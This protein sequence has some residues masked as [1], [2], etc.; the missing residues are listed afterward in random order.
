MRKAVGTVGILAVLVGLWCGSAGA[1]E[2]SHSV[3]IPGAVSSV[4][5][6]PNL[7]GNGH[8]ELTSGTYAVFHTSEGDFIAS[9]HPEW[10]P[11]AVDNFTALASGI[12]RWRH[13]VTLE[14]TTRPLYSNTTVYRTMPNG[15]I[16]GGD[17]IN[18]GEADSGT[19]LPLEAG[20][21]AKFN[22]PGLLAMDSSGDK[23]SGSRW[24][25][26]LRPFPERT[27]SYSIFGKIIGGLD[28]VQRIS[29]KPVK[30]PQLPL[31]PVMVYFVEIVRIPPGRMTTGDF[32]VED[33]LKVL[34]IQPN[35]QDAPMIAESTS[36]QSET[37][38]TT[39]SE[40]AETESSRANDDS[41]N[42]KQ[43][44]STKSTSAE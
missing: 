42:Q 20:T 7:S 1:Q 33:G 14:E 6:S 23:V 13:P 34:R 9:L 41:E 26:T 18:R 27:G 3:N 2:T 44:T 30:R 4:L 12:K 40:A 22:S 10:A 25:I 24:F 5:G 36:D 29:L 38:E 17:P 31:D 32:K 8:V 43:D 37:E 15:M 39:E 28:T 21:D 35:F 16:F 11:T 19:Q